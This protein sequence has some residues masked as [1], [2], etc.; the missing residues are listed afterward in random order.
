MRR[1]PAATLLLL[2]AVL[3]PRA[4]TAQPAA[5]CPATPCVE[6]ATTLCLND[7]RFRVTLDWVG[8][9]G[10]SGDG[11]APP[12][13]LT[14]DTSY[15]WFFKPTNAELVVKVLDGCGVN[16]HYWVFAGGLTNVEVEMRVCD[17]AAGLERVYTNTQ[18]TSFEPVQDTAAFATCP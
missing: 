2:L 8:P 12:E 16:G 11:M 4:A 1:P 3:L 7:D 9:Q 5:T 17:T 6:D 13:E 14:P 10:G 18:G 15:F